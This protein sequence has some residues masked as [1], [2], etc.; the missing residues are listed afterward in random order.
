MHEISFPG[1]GIG[2]FEINKVA[3][4]LFGHPVAWYGIIIA[5]GMVAAFFI[6]LHFAKREGIKSDDMIDLALFLLIA[7][8]VGARIYYVIFKF[9]NF[10]VTGNGFFGNIGGTLKNIVAIWD[11]GLGFYGGLILSFIVAWFVARKKKIRFPVLIDTVAPGLILAQAI[12]RWGNFVNAEAY[13][14]QTDL[15]WRMGIAETKAGGLYSSYMEVHPTFL[16]ESLWNLIGFAVMMLIY[17]KK[18]F[19]GQI[20]YFYMMWYGFGRFFIEG[21]RTDSLYLF[22]NVRVSQVVAVMT[23]AVGLV[24]TVVMWKRSDAKKVKAAEDNDIT[25]NGDN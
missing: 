20:F 5:C 17:R 1:F 14:T 6:A 19:N 9:D 15:P 10:L 11:G 23:F 22:A 8:I 12:G 25:E 13:G 4:T 16:Y 21:L 24:L 18:K 3:F 2:P 7:S